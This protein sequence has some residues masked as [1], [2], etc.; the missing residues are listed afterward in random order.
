MDRF[1]PTYTKPMMK[2]LD[3]EHSEL[4]RI[5]IVNR[6]PNPDRLNAAL[7]NHLKQAIHSYKGILVVE[8]VKQDGFGVMS[9]VLRQALSELAGQNLDSII[10]VDSR[11]FGAAY[12]N[13]SLKM[14]I[15]EAT[16][17]AA[18]L[19][20]R[21]PENF[22]ADLIGSRN[23]SRILWEVQRGLVLSRLAIKVCVVW[24]IISSFISRLSV[25]GRID[26]VGAG[27]LS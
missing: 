15:H 8:Q 25:E 16:N 6:S 10:M 23:C 26:I 9:P 3:G 4:N 13:V 20:G 12:R 5:D 24:T 11:H 1:T 21:N 27:D 2:E 22:T 7:V 19:T 14:N 18:E 17:V